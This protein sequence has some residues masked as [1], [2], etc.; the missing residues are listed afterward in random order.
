MDKV[1]VRVLGF[2]L[3]LATHELGDHDKLLKHSGLWFFIVQDFVSNFPRARKES[4]WG[5]ER[6][7]RTGAHILQAIASGLTP[8]P[9]DPQNTVRNNPNTKQGVDPKH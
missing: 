6:V 5:R 2:F 7:L 4:V 8:V 9:H 1:Q 3:R